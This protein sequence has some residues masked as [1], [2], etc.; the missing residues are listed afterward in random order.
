MAGKS[1]VLFLSHH[2]EIGGGEMSLLRFLRFL[3]RNKFNAFAD[4]GCDGPLIE[5]LKKLDIKTS[6]LYLP[7]SFRTLK[8]DPSRKNKIAAVLRTALMF[9]DLVNKLKKI[10][11]EKKIAITYVNTVKSAC[12][13]IPAAKKANVKSVWRLHDCLTKEFY[14]RFFLWAIRETTKD[15]DIVIC[16]S[17]TVKKEYL[18]LIGKSRA[19]KI[20]T[21]SNGVDMKEFKLGRKNEDLKSNLAKKEER[22]ISLIGRLEPWKGQE[23][24]IRAAEI[25]SST[26][27]DTQPSRNDK[28]SLKFLIVGG[29]L[30]GRGEYE[31]K[32]KVLIKELKLEKKVILL[33]QRD[34]V[35]DSIAISDMIVHTSYLPEPFGRDIIEAMACGKPVISTNVGSPKEIITPE[36]GI[37]IEPNRPDILADEIMKLLGNP[38]KMKKM[39]ENAR[40]R[41]EELYDIKKVTK[42]IEK[43]L[44]SV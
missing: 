37:L 23:T 41:A 4:I 6:I 36:T 34:D 33:G 42:S 9:N 5:E 10:I 26:D 2:A 20:Y 30:F 44:L 14:G 28:L 27:R 13:G 35:P 38:S 8:R 31:N 29:P 7:E 32:L 18:K 19:P 12:F 43:I 17:E 25:V 24:F 1:N 40:K 22:I 15:V 3:N 39:G 16:T 21:V 11:I